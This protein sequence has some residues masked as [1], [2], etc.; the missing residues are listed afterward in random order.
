MNQN[1]PSRGGLLKNLKA[2]KAMIPGHVVALGLAIMISFV[3]QVAFPVRP[4]VYALLVFAGMFGLIGDILNIIYCRRR[5]K[6]L[7]R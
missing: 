6:E 1:S 2:S 3:L 7:D 5:L 4:W